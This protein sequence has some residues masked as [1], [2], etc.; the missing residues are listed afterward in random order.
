MLK[1]VGEVIFLTIKSLYTWRQVLSE[2]E[3]SQLED[4]ALK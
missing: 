2:T 1:I 3:V 4:L